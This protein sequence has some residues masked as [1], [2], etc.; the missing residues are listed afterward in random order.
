MT[1]MLCTSLY[2]SGK[3]RSQPY[4]LWKWF[5]LAA[6]LVLLAEWYIYNRRVYV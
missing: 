6:F 3:D 2:A 1:A 4:E 5:V